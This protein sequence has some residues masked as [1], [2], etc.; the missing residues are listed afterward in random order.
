MP[1][2]LLYNANFGRFRADQ[3]G[4]SGVGYTLIDSAGTVSAPRTTS[5]V[6]QAAPGSGLYAA[7]VS[8]PDGFHGQV[9]WDCPAFTGSTGT[10]FAASYAVE[11]YNVEANDPRVADTWQMVSS[12]TGSV[13][14]L[15]DV[16]FGRWRIDPA[17]NRM[18]FYREDNATVVATFALFDETGTPAFDGIFER[19]LVG[20]VTP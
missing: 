18:V 8:F 13:Q 6:Y 12:I 7:Y 20:V 1:L 9:V 19:R 10:V 16:A 11:P 17:S 15:Y 4:S 2:Q 5:G 14:G 3:T